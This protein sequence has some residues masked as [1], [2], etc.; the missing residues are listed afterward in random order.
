MGQLKQSSTAGGG[1]VWTQTNL[2]LTPQETTLLYKGMEVVDN[3]NNQ[4]V[5]GNKTFTGTV[6]INNAPVA[7]TDG[8]NKAY[9]DGLS[10][11]AVKSV[12]GTDPIV[13]TA[14]KTPVISIKD[15][16]PTQKGSMSAADKAKL[17][18]H[19]MNVVN[20]DGDTMTGNL[21]TSGGFYA[22]GLISSKIQVIAQDTTNTYSTRMTV[23]GSAGYFQAG[24]T[25]R[26]VADQKL[27]LSGWL[28]TPLTMSKFSMANGVN[29]QVAWGSTNHDILHR[30]NMPTVADIS[31]MGRYS[32]PDGDD[33]NNAIAPGNYGIG[34][35]T[36]NTP[37]GSGPSGSTLLVLTWE[38]GT[39]SVSQMF[40]SYTQDRVWIRK[41]YTGVWQPWFEL[42]SSAS[43][44][45]VGGAGTGVD[46]NPNAIT[47]TGGVRDF[48]LV[49][50]NGIF[51]TDGSWLN[52]T[53]NVAT[54]VTHN[55]ILEVKQRSFDN[56]TIQKFTQ[57]TNNYGVTIENVT[58]R[59]WNNSTDGWSPWVK[60]GMWEN[61][62]MYRSGILRLNNTGDDSVYPY[63]SYTKEK[64][65]DTVAVGTGYTIGEI[66][67]RVNP[68]NR[69]DPHNA[70]LLG[71]IHGQVFNTETANEYDGGLFLASR[72]RKTDNTTADSST[73]S[74]NRLV[75]AE[76]THAAKKVNISAGVVTAENFLQSTA[77]S[78]LVNSSTRKDYVDGEI[79]KQVAK[80]GDTM[81]GVLKVSAEIQSLS[82]HSYRQV[83]GNYGTFWRTDGTNH[84]LMITNSG[85]QYGTYNSLRPIRTELATGKIYLGTDSFVLNDTQKI[86][87]DKY[88]PRLITH[89]YNDVGSDLNTIVSAGNVS[90]DRF[91]T[92]AANR[93][94]V[95]NS[96]NT[97][98][99]VSGVAESSSSSYG[100]QLAFSSD[101]KMYNRY[102][103]N[104]SWSGWGQ[105]YTT[106]Y[107][108]TPAEVGA[109]N[110]TGDTMTGNLTVPV[111][112]LSGSQNSAPNT[113]TRKDYVDGEIA[114]Q[115]AKT[116]STMTGSL[117]MSGNTEIRF[118]AFNT[119]TSIAN[120]NG[121]GATQDATNIQIKSWQGIGISPTAGLPVGMTMGQN[122]IW[123]N[124]RTGAI[125]SIGSVTAYGFK[126]TNANAYFSEKSGHGMYL[127]TT[128][129][130]RTVIGGGS[131]TDGTVLIRPSGTG[132]ST[133]QTIFET[134]GTITNSAAPTS[135]GHLTNKGYV[136]SAIAAGDAL[137]VSKTGDIMTGN[138]TI[139]PPTG[140]A[141]VNIDS[142]SGQD[143]NVV[144]QNGG[145]N[146]WNLY[147]NNAAESTGNNG[148]NFALRAFND[149]S[150]VL[151]DAF[152][153][154]R[155]S[156][157][158]TFL[159]N[160]RSSATQGT[161]VADLTRKDY[162]D[163]EIAKQVSKTGD[164]M[165]GALA[166]QSTTGNWRIAPAGAGNYGSF[167]HQDI[168]NLYLMLTNTNNQTG[169]YNSLRPF[170]VS[171]SSGLVSIGNGL[172][173]PATQGTDGSSATRK[174]YVDGQVA[175]KVS[176]AGDTMSG[177]LTLTASINGGS[178]VDSVGSA[179]SSMYTAKLPHVV[180]ANITGSSY[181]PIIGG[182]YINN[183]GWQGIYSV[184][185]L[186]N[187]A[188]DP[189]SFCIHH[190][191]GAGG[192]AFMWEF[193]GVT[194]N[195][196]CP[197]VMSTGSSQGTGANSLTRK[198]YV[199][200]QVAT[201]A[202]SSHNHTAAQGNSNVVAGEY[203][204]VG[205]YVL[206]QK[207]SGPTISYGAN[208]AGATLIPASAGNRFWDGNTLPG[209]W[210]C[211]GYAFDTSA[212]V[213][214]RTSLFIRIS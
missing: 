105:V 205:S 27:I 157:I 212:E 43:K 130:N 28:G 36:T 30:G 94:T 198:D 140:Q 80:A 125:N 37:V 76:F 193:N 68:T 66:G 81:T 183:N 143:S 160:P 199:D 6:K 69:Y 162:V 186:N 104:V 73:I 158:T 150:S 209:T 18:N 115:V 4:T 82:N 25:D 133:A 132:I 146:R 190:I 113:V 135:T 14:G 148:S 42:Y 156:R 112:N 101:G 89:V 108:P 40:I 59:A 16:T 177:T 110:K 10:A 35:F 88:A 144:F 214:Q 23:S 41:R 155:K 100:H 196:Y 31:A 174:D 84:Y 13:A 139:K 45:P 96:A 129:D 109:V 191:N 185:L 116:G 206:A 152:T 153:V 147:Q 46:D 48:N 57:I 120:G 124:A 134:N 93:P 52:G 19:P 164:T 20:K 211:M 213:D 189:G 128:T 2:P 53:T 179:L 207:T 149:D 98:L 106:I 202:P 138:L 204:A 187:N 194:G 163:G 17:D 168:N 169:T 170:A 192:Q 119:G 87:H 47:V 55:G 197:G 56:L 51:T 178:A 1:L 74:I 78:N 7:T 22:D 121:D 71:R 54:G 182:R 97:I 32:R 200:G 141:R 111:V 26:D 60:D 136:D 85:D 34:G 165:T 203:Y 107:R 151:G 65:R 131:A 180:Y 210:K 175:S 72:L 137:Q 173:L 167:W 11:Q 114:K 159:V 5:G 195:F 122:S 176:K 9:A 83:A 15:A 90:F 142:V 184:G 39:T 21:V 126:A 64:Y 161:N 29:P 75:G 33:C 208:V 49:K 12:T 58:S 154:E 86:F 92:Q 8:V 63:V 67:F 172:V 117:S 70:D 61:V 79:A 95:A 77:Q 38:T 145:K 123:I 3:T 181:S 91:S 171:L 166:T 24:K 99:N 44:Q 127:G 50:T 62:S 118:T 201:R 102:N 188:A 103:D